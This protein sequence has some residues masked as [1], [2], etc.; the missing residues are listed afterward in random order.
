MENKK[1]SLIEENSNQTGE[2]SDS[3]IR[4]TTF[5]P[6]PE[7]E[8]DQDIKLLKEMGFDE[9]M[10]KKV[11]LVLRPR[12]LSEAIEMMSEQNGMYQHDFIESRASSNMEQCY[13]C[14]KERRF[15]RDYDR[16]IRVRALLPLLWRLLHIQT[17]RL[18]TFRARPRGGTCATLAHIRARILLRTP[19]HTSE[20]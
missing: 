16:K 11:Y 19:I 2:R 14:K 5:I 3:F 9:G 8:N 17:G 15:H 1:E 18:A 7:S 20:W 12:N 13:I 4:R 6:T 10:V